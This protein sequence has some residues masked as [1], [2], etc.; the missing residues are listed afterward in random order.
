MPNWSYDPLRDPEARKAIVHECC[1]LCGKSQCVLF[2][3]GCGCDARKEERLCRLCLEEALRE[4]R[5][6]ERCSS[7]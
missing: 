3:F 2:C 7:E 5:A 4:V 1:V 6:T